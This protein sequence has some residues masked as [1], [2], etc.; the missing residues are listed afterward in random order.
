MKW[1]EASS[2]V[3]CFQERGGNM[4]RILLIILLGI[5]PFI[6]YAHPSDWAQ[7]AQE[8]VTVDNSVVS[9][10]ISSYGTIETAFEYKAEASLETA[11]IRF[12][13]KSTLAPYRILEVGQSVVLFN[14]TEIT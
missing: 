12:T 5:L 4:K 14:D 1:A 10:S 9:L 2:A 3:L 6:V 7:Y 13:L 8:T 11:Q